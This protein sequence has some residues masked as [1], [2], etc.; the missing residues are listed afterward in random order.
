MI[1]VLI[2]IDLWTMIPALKTVFSQDLKQRPRIVGRKRDEA[3]GKD[4]RWT[5]KEQGGP[6]NKASNIV[7]RL[8]K[9]EDFEA[10]VGIDAKILNASRPEYYTMKFEKLFTSREYVPTSLVAETDDKTVV[11]FVMGELYMGEFGIFQEEAAL[12][13]IGVDPDHRHQGVGE[14]L[15]TE[16]MEHLKT[17]GVHKVHTLV[18]RNDSQLI[19]FFSA[20]Q[21]VP[22]DIVN[23]ERSL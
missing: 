9:A 18:G 17:L 13:T 8:M 1:S 14:Q 22:S 7:I 20:N 12:D 21:F 16:F 3:Q 19:N 2:A 11:G 6:M 4:M 23:L 5:P 15:M 10:V